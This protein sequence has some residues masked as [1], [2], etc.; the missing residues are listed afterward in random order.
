M[1]ISFTHIKDPLI[2][3][4]VESA[5]QIFVES[6]KDTDTLTKKF[7]SKKGKGTIY[8]IAK[9]FGWTEGKAQGSIKRLEEA[10]I[11]KQIKSVEENGRTKKFY[12]LR[13]LQELLAD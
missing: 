7:I 12:V 11:I 2:R 9:H 3:K 4:R 10:K 5:V 8:D 1:E 13:T 6:G